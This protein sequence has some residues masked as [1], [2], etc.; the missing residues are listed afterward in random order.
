MERAIGIE[1]ISPEWN[2]KALPT[3]TRIN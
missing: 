1:P 3:T 2:S